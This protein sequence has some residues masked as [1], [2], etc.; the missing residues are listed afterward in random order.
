MKY[1]YF[2]TPEIA[3]TILEDLS[4]YGYKPSLIVTSPDK[5]A[6]RKLVLTPSHVKSWAIK[7]NIPFITPDRLRNDEVVEKLKSVAADIFIVAAYGKLIP[8]IIL[9]IPKYKTINVHPSNLPLLRGPSPIESVITEGLLET[10]VS[11]M[12][13]DKD[14]DHGPIIAQ[15]DDFIKWDINNP[16]KTSYLEE[17]LAHKG[18][19]LLIDI[20]P[21]WINGEIK[22]IEQDHSKATFCKKISK[23][24]GLIEINGDPIIAIRKIRAYNKWP[25]AFFFLEHNDKK[26]RIRVKE[27]KIE[28]EKLIIQRVVPE[29][30]NEMNY[31]D[32]LRGIK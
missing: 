6:G 3:E 20:L 31:E 24:D 28:N 26:I 5:P 13:L 32:F 22:S 16:P 29:G 8:Q 21:K 18:A 25:G 30:K 15:D 27:A 12:E 1:I 17:V 14:M 2:G 11:I 23:E 7:N 4:N 9:D 19:S 10:T